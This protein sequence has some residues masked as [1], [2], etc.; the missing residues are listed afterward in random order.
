MPDAQGGGADDPA[1]RRDVSLLGGIENT[2]DGSVYLQRKGQ[3]PVYSAEGG[4]RWSL[5]KSTYE[6]RTKELIAFDEPKVKA[7]EVKGKLGS[8]AVGARREEGLAAHPAA[9]HRRRRPLAGVDAGG[10]QVRA[11]AL[12]PRRHPEAR[13]AFGLEAPAWDATF[14]L[15]PARRCGCAWPG[16]RREGLRAARGAGRHGA[17]GRGEP[18]GDG[19]ARQE[20]RRLEGQGGALVQ[21]RRGRPHQLPPGGRHRGEG[22]EAAA[23]GRRGRERRLGRGRPAAGPGKKWKLSSILGAWAR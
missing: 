5:E 21:A 14:T 8:Y 20:P 11:G 23:A 4:V 15:D 10:A 17:P 18:F 9:G 7:L 1:R 13:V 6:L 2:F 22:A 19:A 3:K 16:G 12:L